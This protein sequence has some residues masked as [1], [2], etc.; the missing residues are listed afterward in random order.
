M[1][2]NTQHTPDAAKNQA[3]TIAAMLADGMIRRL[4]IGWETV[5]R[6]TF[7]A[8]V[9]REAGFEVWFEEGEYQ[10][11]FP[12]RAALAKAEGRA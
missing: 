11:R 5:G 2:Q 9:A 1:N 8:E 7:A 12:A 10:I 6:D 3:D 4:L